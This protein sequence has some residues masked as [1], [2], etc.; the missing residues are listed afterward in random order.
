MIAA[1]AFVAKIQDQIAIRLAGMQNEQIMPPTARQR[2]STASP[3]DHV[4]SGQATDRIV[5]SRTN[6][7]VIVFFASSQFT[8]LRARSA[9]SV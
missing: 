5:A 6:K 8:K 2:V 7:N 9:Q 3:I 4:I 1:G